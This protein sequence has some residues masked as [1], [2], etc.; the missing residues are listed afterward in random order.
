MFKSMD[1]CS[2]M[3][4]YSFVICSTV[5]LLASS[6]YSFAAS[7]AADAIS[8]DSVRIAWTDVAIFSSEDVI[9]AWTS[10][11]VQY[12]PRRIR[13]VLDSDTDTASDSVFSCVSVWIC[14]NVFTTLDSSQVFFCGS[15]GY[16][17]IF[18][19]RCFARVFS[20]FDTIHTVSPMS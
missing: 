20:V 19:I 12:P 13:F 10:S 7:S 11:V 6:A 4:W 3:V 2:I 18:T 17:V 9:A 1:V 15:F 16:S 14:S 5:L 8:R